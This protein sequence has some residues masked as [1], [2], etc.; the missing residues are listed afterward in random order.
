M[1]G[2]QDNLFVWNFNG[3]NLDVSYDSITV[4]KSSTGDSYGLIVVSSNAN[5]PANIVT[6]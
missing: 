4:T 5:I 3:Q 1:R 6:I 2:Y